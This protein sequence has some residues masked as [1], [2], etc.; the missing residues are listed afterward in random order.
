MNFRKT[1]SAA[2]RNVFEQ[3]LLSNQE[4][5]VEVTDIGNLIDSGEKYVVIFHPV[6][7]VGDIYPH[8][9]R[10]ILD[11]HVVFPQ[12]QREETE[13]AE[14]QVPVFGGQIAHFRVKGFGQI[15][16]FPEKLYLKDLQ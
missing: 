13:P 8:L 10:D 9:C 6:P 3:F 15:L 7:P 1:T 2:S 16:F 14:P 5:D 11:F 4:T 12:G